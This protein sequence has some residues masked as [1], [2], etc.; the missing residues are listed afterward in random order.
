MDKE[1]IQEIIDNRIDHFE[2][3]ITLPG[4]PRSVTFSNYH[5]LAW[6]KGKVRNELEAAL[7]ALVK[8]RE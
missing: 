6:I 4:L 7:T 1:A 8:V 3:E 5:T 2:R